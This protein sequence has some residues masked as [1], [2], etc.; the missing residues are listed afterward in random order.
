MHSLS[1]LRRLVKF[2]IVSA[3]SLFIG[4][5]H[6]MLQVFPPIRAWLDSIGSPYGGPGHMI[7]PLAHAHMNLVGGVVTLAMGITYYLLPR[8][9]GKRIYSQRLVQH[10]FWWLFLGVYGFYT[11]QMVFGI[12][13]GYLMLHDRAA[14]THA[15]H[16]Y[17]PIVAVAGT[18]M[19]VGFMVYFSNIVL[20]L[21]GPVEST[22]AED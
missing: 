9:S 16:F 14:M 10:S 20:T 8:L 18:C 7:D 5:M 1:D 13:E 12:W 17:G 22:R 19:A 15:H 21:M 11:T 4:A 6:G 3:T 2:F